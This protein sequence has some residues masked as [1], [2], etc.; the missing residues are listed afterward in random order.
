[1]D[2]GFAKA[3][4][5]EVGQKLKDH[6]DTFTGKKVTDSVETFASLYGDILLGMHRELQSQDSRIQKLSNVVLATSVVAVLA[7]LVAGWALW[8]RV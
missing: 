1:M 7:L 8:I 5:A 4:A 3:K 6:R 2:F